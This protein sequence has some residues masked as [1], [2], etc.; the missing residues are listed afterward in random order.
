MRQRILALGAAAA[1]GASL[2]LGG[3]S[4]FGGAESGSTATASAICPMDDSRSM[5][6]S[7]T[8]TP[9]FF[10]FLVFHDDISHI[11]IIASIHT[12][13]ILGLDDLFTME[14]IGIHETGKTLFVAPE[15]IGYLIKAHSFFRF[16]ENL[17]DPYCFSLSSSNLTITSSMDVVIEPVVQ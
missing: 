9:F 11:L 13:K 17:F 8:R 12:D 4:L 6:R 15:I 2:L 10:A 16:S 14:Q 1:L 5:V 3:C 7:A